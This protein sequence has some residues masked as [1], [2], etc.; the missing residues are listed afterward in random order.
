MTQ[1]RVTVWNHISM[2]ERHFS[3]LPLIWPYVF[4]S[5]FLFIKGM[6]F[7]YEYGSKIGILDIL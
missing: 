3:A 2:A 7:K 5:A 1:E 4:L 6:I